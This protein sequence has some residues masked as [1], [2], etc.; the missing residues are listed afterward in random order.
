MSDIIIPNNFRARSYQSAVC[1]ALIEDGYKRA[2]CVWHRRSGKDKTFL[3]IMIT[4]MLERVGIYYYFFPS[5]AQGRKALCDMIDKDQFP[6][7]QH[8]PEELI[9]SQNNT[10]MKIRLKNGSLFQIIGTD[11]FDSIMGTGPV[12]CVF[13]EY[14]L[15]D[16][17]VK[18]FVDPMLMETK[19]WAIYNCTP[20]GRNHAFKLFHD[21]K[22]NDR[23]F[24]EL[25]TVDD[26]KL[27]DGSPAMPKHLIDQERE[28]GA[29]EAYIQQEYY[30]S[31]D[32]ALT[33]CFFGDT[34]V[35]HRDAQK[36][37]IGNLK[38]GPRGDIDF[39]ESLNGILE[40]WR[41]PYNELDD[42]DGVT[43]L[44]RYAIGSDICEGLKQDYSVA[45]VLDRVRQEFVARMRS[46]TIDAY[47]WAN[48]LYRLSEYYGNAIICPERTGA[49][50]TTVKRLMDLN[51][52]L[53]VREV[54]AKIGSGLTKEFGWNNNSK[55]AKYDLAGDL[56][57]YFR[58]TKSTIWDSTLIFE[59]ST[60]IQDDSGRLN[61]EGDFFD[62]CVISAGCT[63]LAHFFEPPP[64]AVSVPK[65]GWRQR[66][67]A[68]MSY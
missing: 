4:K 14:S 58:S 35:R 23:W 11:N 42:Y 59:G 1:K 39:E 49:G 40:I 16:P 46:N 30:C 61:A 34:L 12:G 21:V 8:F 32:A 56:K 68:G 67:A 50:I 63:L 20:R 62:D 6:V 22:D 51:A 54:P 52:N 33:L 36:G 41:F 65:E 27:P 37:L 24:T 66:R 5:Y 44:R 64:E 17:L 19:G 9:E 47:R 57:E 48:L 43:W 10:E 2:F 13:S 28:D 26:T 25:L 18:T 31:W 60:Y 15:Q 3:N 45:H 7:I 38:K 29:T 55:Q 53:Y